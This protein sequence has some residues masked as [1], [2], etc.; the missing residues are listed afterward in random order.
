[1]YLLF[2]HETKGQT[3]NVRMPLPTSPF[4]RTFVSSKEQIAHCK[5]PRLTQKSTDYEDYMQSIICYEKIIND[6][7]YE[8]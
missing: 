8:A 6:F 1:M 3:D 2:S 7:R 4:L 5:I